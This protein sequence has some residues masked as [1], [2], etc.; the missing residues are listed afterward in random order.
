MVLQFLYPE[1]C[2]KVILGNLGNILN[3]KKNHMKSDL[4]IPKFEM[5]VDVSFI[6]A[7]ITDV[8]EASPTRQGKM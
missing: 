6:S 2:W 4:I 5:N 8:P 1:D 3:N 7:G